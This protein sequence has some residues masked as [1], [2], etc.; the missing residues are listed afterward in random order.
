MKKIKNSLRGIITISKRINI[1]ILDKTVGKMLV[2]YIP[3]SIIV[4]VIPLV[5]NFVFGEVVNRFSSHKSVF[6]EMS[7]VVVSIALTVWYLTAR[8]IRYYRIQS[9]SKMEQHITN[10]TELKYWQA[11]SRLDLQDRENPEV[12]DAISDAQRNYS[13]V[14]GIFNTQETLVTSF[15]A[16]A[17]SLTI[18]GLLEWW[19]ILIIIVMI[20]PSLYQNNRRKKKDYKQQKRLNEIKRYKGEL[21][22]CIGTKETIVNG[23]TQYFLS[24]YQ[25]IAMKLNSMSLKL[26]LKFERINLYSGLWYSLLLGFLFYHIFTKIDKGIIQIGSIFLI[27]SAL[28]QIYMNLNLI[29]SKFVDFQDLTR[30]A[31]DFFL[32]LD[33]KP[34]VSNSPDAVDIDQTAPPVIEFHNVWFKYPTTDVFVLKGINLTIKAGERIGLVGENGEGKTSLA[35]LLLRFYDPTIGYISING[36]DLLSVKRESLHA[37]SGVVFQDFGLFQ[38]RVYESIRS[39]AVHKNSF[40]DVVDAAKMA[41]I[42][43]YINALPEGYNHKIGKLYKNGTKLS[44]GQRQKIAIASLTYRDPKLMVVD[45]LTSAL[46]PTAEDEIVQHY[47]TI[48]QGKTCVVICQRYKSLQ[49][50]DRIIVISGGVIAENGTH[51]QLMEIQGLYAHLY[52]SAQL[53]AV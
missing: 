14:L 15:I 33:M 3:C 27:L 24:L 50:V 32:I 49:F 13:A 52:S 7:L 44:G 42:H 45:E 19:Y 51:A 25:S 37:L 2:W 8:L 21:A 43:D 18:I 31:N 16:F 4:S 17:T 46:S 39:S 28:D 9:Q 30:R 11:F 26:K 38:T 36:I 47:S 12:Q 23:A 48:T 6:V 10:K 53:K 5:T 22:S 20:I 40:K 29:L 34:A 1:F 41:G 35:L